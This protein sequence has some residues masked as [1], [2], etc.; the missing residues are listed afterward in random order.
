[1]QKKVC[2]IFA[3]L[4]E[5]LVNVTSRIPRECDIAN[6]SQMWHHESLVKMTSW[7]LHVRESEIVM[8][9]CVK[10]TSR[11]PHVR[12][13]H[14]VTPSFACMQITRSRR[15]RLHMKGALCCCTIISLRCVRAVANC[16]HGARNIHVKRLREGRNVYPF[17]RCSNSE[18]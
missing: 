13:W 12:K 16:W 4:R 14:C 8:S 11:C 3:K 17:E 15:W 10:V 2:N 5:S 6:P 18:Y 7:C 1:M 9:P